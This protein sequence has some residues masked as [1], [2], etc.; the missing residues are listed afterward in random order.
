MSPLKVTGQLSFFPGSNGF[1]EF[2][3]SVRI[4]KRKKVTKRIEI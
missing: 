4:K 3:Y 2:S 1:F